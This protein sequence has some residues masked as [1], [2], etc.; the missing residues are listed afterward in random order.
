MVAVCL[1]DL[2]YGKDHFDVQIGVGGGSPTRGGSRGLLNLGLGGNQ[3][4]ILNLS[5]WLVFCPSWQKVGLGIHLD[6]W[7]LS[8]C[9]GCTKH[10]PRR[11]H[12]GSC[13]GGKLKLEL[14]FPMLISTRLCGGG[15][16]SQLP[17]VCV[18]VCTSSVRMVQRCMFC[19]Q[20]P[21]EPPPPSP[22][23]H[24][25][26]TYLLPLPPLTP[27]RSASTHQP[28]SWQIDIVSQHTSRNSSV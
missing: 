4:A 9:T 25:S 23:P 10:Q 15:V 8:C 6:R 12:L 22:T 21:H 3:Y 24:L 16:K 2:L 27:S 28:P 18:P 20:C 14:K 26:P 7:G 11:P 19:S 17:P 5:C 13:R 1:N